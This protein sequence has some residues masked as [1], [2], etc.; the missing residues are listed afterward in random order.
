M[1]I[2]KKELNQLR[3]SFPQIVKA[4]ILFLFSSSGLGV[5]LFLRFLGHNGTIIAF[6]AILVE[7]LAMMLSYFMFRKYF[8][9]KEETKLEKSRKSQ[10]YK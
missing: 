9:E 5:A 2:I 8:R 3:I 4:F 7:S 6:I 1:S 10:S